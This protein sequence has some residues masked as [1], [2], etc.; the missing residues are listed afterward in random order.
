[1]YMLSCENIDFCDPVDTPKEEMGT[2]NAP[3]SWKDQGTAAGD[4]GTS[5]GVACTFSRPESHIKPMESAKS[6]C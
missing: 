4:W 5:N 1:M 6:P 3:F 2:Q